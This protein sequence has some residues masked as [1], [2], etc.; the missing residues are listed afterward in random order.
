MRNFDHIDNATSI[1]HFGRTKNLTLMKVGRTTGKT[2][3]Q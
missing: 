2:R 1:M 3:I